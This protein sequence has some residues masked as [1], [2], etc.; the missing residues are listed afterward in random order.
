[1]SK[2][3]REGAEATPV[4]TGDGGDLGANE[5]KAAMWNRLAF[6]SS[7]QESRLSKKGREIR[8]VPDRFKNEFRKSDLDEWRKWVHYDEVE[9][10]T[11]D[12]AA[13]LDKSQV[14]PLRPVRTDKNEATRGDKSFEA[15]PLIAKTRL[16]C[17]GY[18]DPQA[19]ANKL[20]TDAPTLSDE[21][22][23]LI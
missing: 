5:A 9:I 17:P 7:R 1:M 4:P 10:V 6:V 12:D 20:Q 22:T 23:A 18:A 3:A 21:G 11:D 8:Q 19:L 16:V 13:T 2:R 14:L 15:H